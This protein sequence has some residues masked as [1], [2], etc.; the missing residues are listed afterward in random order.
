VAPGAGFTFRA[1]AGVTRDAR[2][3]RLPTHTNL[4]FGAK[5]AHLVLRPLWAGPMHSAVQQQQQ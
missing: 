2:A 5:N 3:A 4:N 1:E